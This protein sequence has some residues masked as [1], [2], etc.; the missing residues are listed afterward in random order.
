[1]ATLSG[2][3]DLPLTELMRAAAMLGAHCDQRAIQ[4]RIV[5]A[6]QVLEAVRIGVAHMEGLAARPAPAAVSPCAVVRLDEFRAAR[7]APAARP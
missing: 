3:M 7:V 1:M 4:E 2:A 5:A 6:V